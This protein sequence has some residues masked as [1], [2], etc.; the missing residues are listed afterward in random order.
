MENPRT[1]I[2]FDNSFT[3]K[4]YALAFVNNYSVIFYLA[5]LKV[6]VPDLVFV[7]SNF[8]KTTNSVLGQIL[9]VSGRQSHF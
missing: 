8:E 6:I 4:S 1:Q 2:E 7:V 9:H 3:Y 5:F